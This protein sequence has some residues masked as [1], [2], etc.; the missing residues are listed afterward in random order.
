[1][2]TEQHLWHYFTEI[3]T[4]VDAGNRGDTVQPYISGTF[5][6]TALSGEIEFTVSDISE[7]DAVLIAG[8]LKDMGIR[9]LVRGTQPCPRCGKRVP[10]QDHC[11]HCRSKLS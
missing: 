5:M 3:K 10:T 9:A 7:E 1:M 4:A 6:V 8:E 11:V 2:N